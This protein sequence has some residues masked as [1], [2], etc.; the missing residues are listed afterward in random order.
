MRRLIDKDNP[1]L[2]KLKRV[3]DFF[4]SCLLF[5]EWRHDAWFERRNLFVSFFYFDYFCEMIIQK[6]L[7]PFIFF[8]FSRGGKGNRLLEAFPGKSYRRCKGS[9]DEIFVFFPWMNWKS[10]CGCSIPVLETKPIKQFRLN[11]AYKNW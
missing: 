9:S 6:D 11:Q 4:F 7:V 5:G 8:F 1:T 10:I 3:F 2:P